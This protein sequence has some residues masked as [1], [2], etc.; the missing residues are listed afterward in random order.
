MIRKISIKVEERRNR[1]EMEDGKK[2]EA[3]Q[4]A[5]CGIN[6]RCGAFSCPH[7]AGENCIISSYI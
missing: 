6:E 7:I 5:Y 1:C 3:P 4:R 2:K